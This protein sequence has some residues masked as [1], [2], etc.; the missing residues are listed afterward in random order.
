MIYNFSRFFEYT[1]IYVQ[2][3]IKT[4]DTV[5]NITTIT[6][7]TELQ[8]VPTE[9]RQNLNYIQY[10]ILITNFLF[11]G[12]FPSIVMIGF[13]VM[14]VRAVDEANKRRARMTRRQQ[15]NITVTSM[16]VSVV[17]VFLVCHSVKLIISAYE[18]S[19]MLSGGGGDLPEEQN[20]M[21]MTA[22]GRGGNNT[23]VNG[24]ALVYNEDLESTYGDD[25]GDEDEY[26][27]EWVEYMTI[28]SHWLLI[29]NSSSN[30]LIYLHKDPKFK[31]VLKEMTL[32]CFHIPHMRITHDDLDDSRVQAPAARMELI[33][34]GVTPG[35]PIG[36]TLVDHVD[37][38]EEGGVA[39][40]NGYVTNM[41]ATSQP[42]ISILAAS[43]NNNSS[44]NGHGSTQLK[45]LQQEELSGEKKPEQQL[46]LPR[47]G[48][49]GI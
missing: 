7:V 16:L 28:I 48:V 23:H 38:G 6:N 45:S 12:I 4:F 1:S 11:M 46:M 5:T 35:S 42:P 18:V 2:I 17:V 49:N 24:S 37:L 19:L 34:R 9:L 21:S 14:V 3:P 44:S 40:E 27:P 32:N 26:W 30:I 22:H 41:A 31:A 25:R 15:R 29:L 47:T 43:S 36:R 13:N 10:Y 33:Q 8:V 39:D 20:D